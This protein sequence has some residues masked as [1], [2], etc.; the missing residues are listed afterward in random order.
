VQPNHSIFEHRVPIPSNSAA[1]FVFYGLILHQIGRFS[2]LHF[3]R[4]S[5]PTAIQRR[6]EPPETTAVPLSLFRI[7]FVCCSSVACFDTFGRSDRRLT[8]ADR[9]RSAPTGRQQVLF[10]IAASC[11][12]TLT[13]FSASSCLPSS[14]PASRLAHILRRYRCDS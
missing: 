8:N 7:Q 11:S 14:L 1:N 13:P 3:R 10:L 9:P 12:Y 6:C 4:W 5:S 2:S